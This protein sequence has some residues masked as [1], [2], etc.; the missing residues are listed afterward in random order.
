MLADLR[1]E[2]NSRQFTLENY[3]RFNAALEAI[4]GTPVLFRHNETPVF[5]DRQLL[6]AMVGSSRDLLAQAVSS[7]GYRKAADAILP[8]QYAVP[9]EASCPLYVQADFGIVRTASGLEPRLVEIQGFPSLY[10]YQPVMAETYR[11]VY[12]L[13]PLLRTYLSDLDAESYRALFAQSVLGE[14]APENVVLLEVYPEKQKTLCDFRMTERMTGIRTVCLT[15][16]E[17]EGRRL[18]YRHEGR[19]VAIHRIYNRVIVDEL[20]RLGVRAPFDW[21]A[22]L[23]VEWA[24]HPNWYFRLS[25]FSIPFFDHPHV[26]RT[27]FLEG[28]AAIPDDLEN[29]VLK[30]LF[31]FAGLGVVIGPTPEQVRQVPDPSNWIL[32]ERMRWEPVIETPHGP[33]MVEVRIMFIWFEGGDPIPVNTIIRSGRGKMMG[34]DHNKN[35]E[36]V[37]ATAAFY[38]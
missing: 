20:D 35:L 9:D 15:E 2:F 21:N 29:W 19:R 1:R 14:H 26:P 33:T 34:V 7:A 8:P 17:V 24:G 10:A 3:Q 37:G 16:V 13:D 23:D 25:K 36:W 30:P 38:R 11:A 12:G 6:D 5:L 28:A 27:V 31:S 22:P 32:Q 18:F 4:T